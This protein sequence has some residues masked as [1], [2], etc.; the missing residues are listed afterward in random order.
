MPLA[1]F[2]LPAANI[3]EESHESTFSFYNFLYSLATVIF[4]SHSNTMDGSIFLELEAVPDSM[5]AM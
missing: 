2:L 4:S 1:L 5:L 3:T